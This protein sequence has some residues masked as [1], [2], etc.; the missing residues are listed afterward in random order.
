MLKFIVL[1]NESVEVL[2]RGQFIAVDPTRHLPGSG[3]GN[4]AW[5]LAQRP[6]LVGFCVLIRE[7][8][9]QDSISEQVFGVCQT[10]RVL[11][12]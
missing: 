11:V 3:V 6:E 8:G 1:G 7:I 10:I 12:R 4:Q 5:L 2:V 9:K